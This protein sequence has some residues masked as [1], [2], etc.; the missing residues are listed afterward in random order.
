MKCSK[1][2]IEIEWDDKKLFCCP[3]CTQREVISLAEEALRFNR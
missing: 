2:H 3:F 1:D